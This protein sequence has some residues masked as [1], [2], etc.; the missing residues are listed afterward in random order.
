MARI[1]P[2]QPDHIVYAGDIPITVVGGGPIL[3][4][5][6][7]RDKSGTV[8][9]PGEVLT[10]ARR[11]RRQFEIEARAKAISARAPDS[12]PASAACPVADSPGRP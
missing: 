5:I 8:D 1:V 11:R 2:N 3:L 10:M 12:P 9:T 6:G 4:C 7:E